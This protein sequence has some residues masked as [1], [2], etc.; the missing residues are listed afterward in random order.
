MEAWSN[1]SLS[2]AEMSRVAEAIAFWGGNVPFTPPP[3]DIPVRQRLSLLW[4]PLVS[5]AGDTEWQK[6][7]TAF[8]AEISDADISSAMTKK[9]M[10]LRQ[11]RQELEG[12][13]TI[14]LWSMQK[15][16]ANRG[17]IRLLRRVNIEAPRWSFWTKP[18]CFLGEDEFRPLKETHGLTGFERIG[19]RHVHGENKEVMLVRS[20]ALLR[21][22]WSLRDSGLLT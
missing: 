3:P 17:L 20:D 2:S 4:S 1:G 9:V 11:I 19:A 7:A 15:K 14:P 12:S 16:V 5:G 18:S 8:L 21:T 22:I 6:C 13:A 10:M